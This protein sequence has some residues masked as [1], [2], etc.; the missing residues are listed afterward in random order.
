MC[1]GNDIGHWI[2][3]SPITPPDSSATSRFTNVRLPSEPRTALSV[4]DRVVVELVEP[5]SVPRVNKAELL[6][7]EM[8]AELVAE[9]TAD[10]SGTCESPSD[11]NQRLT[12]V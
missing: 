7:V 8:M 9:G 6:E 10:T 5:A 2:T 1:S 12:I 11:T 3:H 4:V